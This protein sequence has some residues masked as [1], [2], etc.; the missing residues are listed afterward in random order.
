M[1]S[2]TGDFASRLMRGLLFL[3][4]NEELLQRDAVVVLGLGDG[5]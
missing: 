1:T 2:H 3:Q 5:V 4:I